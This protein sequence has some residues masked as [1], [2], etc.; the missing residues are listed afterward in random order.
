[1]AN[2]ADIFKPVELKSSKFTGLP[3]G[4]ADSVSGNTFLNTIT[5][6]LLVSPHKGLRSKLPDEVEYFF[7]SPDQAAALGDS[8][9]MSR[10]GF[11]FAYPQPKVEVGDQYKHLKPSL[12][13]VIENKDEFEIKLQSSTAIRV[14]EFMRH[15][16]KADIPEKIASFVSETTRSAVYNTIVDL[17]QTF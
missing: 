5:N 17:F 12:I 2:I 14:N 6:Y 7:M 9:A 13:P 10:T 1:M 11:T 4:K 16:N 8:F 3:L 15:Y